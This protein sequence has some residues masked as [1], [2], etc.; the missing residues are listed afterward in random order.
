MEEIR[1]VVSTSTRDA[2]LAQA[3]KVRGEN[4]KANFAEY[5][6]GIL[7]GY[8]NEQTAKCPIR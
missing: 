4:G 2:L 8:L 5:V 1:V 3:E 6:G 7:D